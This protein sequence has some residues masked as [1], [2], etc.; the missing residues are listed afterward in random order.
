MTKIYIQIYVRF[1]SPDSR[2]AV[3]PYKGDD[4]GLG[5]MSGWRGS[6]EPK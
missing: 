6:T 5:S 4:I 2:H 3:P 1:I